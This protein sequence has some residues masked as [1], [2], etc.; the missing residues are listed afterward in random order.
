MACMYVY[1]ER[2]GFGIGGDYSFFLQLLQQ[3]FRRILKFGRCDSSLNVCFFFWLLLL[4]RWPASL[5]RQRSWLRCLRVCR[6][7][8]LYPCLFLCVW[9]G[10]GAFS[11]WAGWIWALWCLHCSGGRWVRGGWLKRGVHRFSTAV[12]A[13][14]DWLWC[15]ESHCS[16]SCFLVK[17]KSFSCTA[18]L[19]ELY[20]KL[21][22]DLSA[23]VRGK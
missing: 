21:Q 3:W 20:N 12:R 8:V 15:F 9:C 2:V 10:C 13:S 6:G 5:S 14:K 18:K 19:V 11:G 23:F 16:F 22:K 17:F 1:E 4:L 7:G